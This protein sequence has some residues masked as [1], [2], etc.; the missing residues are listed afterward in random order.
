MGVREVTTMVAVEYSSWPFCSPDYDNDPFYTQIMATMS[1]HDGGINHGINWPCSMEIEEA[2]SLPL[3][4]SAVALVFCTALYFMLNANPK[5][6][7]TDEECNKQDDEC[8]LSLEKQKK[9]GAEMNK[10]AD[11]VQTGAKAFLAEEYFWLSIFVVFLFCT[12]LVLFTVDTNRTDRTDGIR[13]ASCFVTGA[14]LS[15][16]AGYVGMIVATDANVRTTQAARSFADGGNKGGGLNSALR[17]AFTGG[18]VMG[19][20]VVGLG[21]LGVSGAMLLMS[22]GTVVQV[23]NIRGRP[24]FTCWIRTWSFEHCPLCS[25]C[26]WNL[27]Q[28]CRCRSRP[29]R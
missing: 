19:F 28:G 13:V 2:M 5:G 20:V 25:C 27:H 1:T 14:A 21:L 10:I 11:E 3:C 7:V 29:C 26:W 15:A 9:I 17:V 22:Q 12:L 16:L 6:P 23:A 8:T 18:A 4:F 24:R